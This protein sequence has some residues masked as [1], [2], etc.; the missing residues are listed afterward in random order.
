MKVRGQL[1]QADLQH[2]IRHTDID[3]LKQGKKPLQI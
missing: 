3:L 2:Y 1:F